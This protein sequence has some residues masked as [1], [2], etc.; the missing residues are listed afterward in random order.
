MKT[1][2]TYYFRLRPPGIGCQPADGLVSI[3]GT[4]DGR[5]SLTHEGYEFWGSAEYS[6]ILTDKEVSQFDIYCDF[7]ILQWGYNAKKQRM[8]HIVSKMKTAMQI[9]E[10]ERYCIIHPAT[11]PGY[12]GQ[13]QISHFDNIG[14]SGHSNAKDKK[15]IVSVLMEYGYKTDVYKYAESEVA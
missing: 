9:G 8:N 10:G 5:R 7:E 6:R 11:R 15:E 3:H 13:W 4:E 12:E 14:P 2:Y 1:T